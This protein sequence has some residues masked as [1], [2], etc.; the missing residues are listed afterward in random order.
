M[1]GVPRPRK[2]RQ[3]LLHIR[4][5][6][7]ENVGRGR[8]KY[9]KGSNLKVH[10]WTPVEAM[11]ILVQAFQRAGGIAYAK[12]EKIDATGPDADVRAEDRIQNQEK[13]R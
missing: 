12:G 6:T 8:Y 7:Y 2:R 13:G 11:R 5:F 4:M 1:A 10:G 3:H 9:I